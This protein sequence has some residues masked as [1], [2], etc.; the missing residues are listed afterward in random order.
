M[1]RVNTHSQPSFNWSC[2]GIIFCCMILHLCPKFG[3]KKHRGPV[4]HRFIWCLAQNIQFGKHCYRNS[5]WNE[6][7][8]LVFDKTVQGQWP[9][10]YHQ[11][12][13][14]TWELYALHLILYTCTLPRIGSEM[15][16]KYLY[17][18]CC[19]WRVISSWTVVGVQ[20]RHKCAAVN[21]KGMPRFRKTWYAVW[22]LFICPWLS[23]LDICVDLLKYNQIQFKACIPVSI[24][25]DLL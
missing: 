20:I 14:V 9:D 16:Y 23:S 17:T 18:V 22:V 24:F 15:D 12:E 8:C 19:W 5:A 13:A 4:P 21:L 3:K 1:A 7:N 10:L 25:I 11:S 2:L 6:M